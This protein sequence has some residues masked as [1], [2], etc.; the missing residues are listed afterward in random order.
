MA[1]DPL[2]R[3][4]RVTR[5]LLVDRVSSSTVAPLA[6]DARVRVT[7]TQPS[8]WIEL[9]KRWRKNPPDAAVAA[10]DAAAPRIA[11]AL[12]GVPVVVSGNESDGSWIRRAAVAAARPGA[13]LQGDASLSIIVPVLNDADAL[14]SLLDTLVPQLGDDD[15]VIVVDGGSTDGTPARA[16]RYADRGVRVLN[17]P[18]TNIPAARNAGVKEARC[19][20]IALTD[21]GCTPGPGWLDAF[22]A[23]F[24]E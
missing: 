10:P 22:R 6:Q 17:R 8:T 21:A 14:E 24:A 18:G 12:S 23:A 3:F 7:D 16:E 20:V 1:D 13:G 9:F 2:Q 19:E 15:E 11:S 5:P 4:E